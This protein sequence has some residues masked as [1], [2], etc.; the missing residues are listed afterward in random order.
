MTVFY[1]G[2]LEVSFTGAISARR[3]DDASHRLSHC[4]KAVD[5][6]VELHDRYLYIE[7][8]DPNHPRS[9]PRD[10][11]RF[12]KRFRSGKL[13]EELKVK[14]RDT[15]LYEW[16]CG[17]ADKPVYF[18]VLVALDGQDARLL[19]PRTTAL[20]RNLPAGRPHSTTWVR[21]IAYDASVFDIARWNSH[22]QNFRVIRRGIN[23]GS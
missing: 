1:E 6:V 17:R 15:F 20:K 3:F 13:D 18:F 4:M 14:F 2:D 7:F 10:R 12:M 22:L 9:R 21:P 11:K 16:A 8:K 23:S 19:G 5:F